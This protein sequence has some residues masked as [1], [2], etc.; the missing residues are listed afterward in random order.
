MLCYAREDPYLDGWINAQK[1]L[2]D[3]H[4][5]SI[6][7]EQKTIRL[8]D[9]KEHFGFRDG[10]SAPL[11]EGLRD[12]QTQLR[13]P[14]TQTQEK[15]I[16][17]GEFVLGYPNEYD[18]LTE[19]PVVKPGDDPGNWLPVYSEDPALKDL[20]KNGTYLVY[21]QLAQHVYR[22][23]K[24][25][26]ENSKEPAQDP[27]QAAVN[28]GA[29]IIGRW[30]GGSP[31]AVSPDHNDTAKEQENHFAYWKED[32]DGMKCPFG[33]HIRRTNPRDKLFGRT[34]QVSIEMIRKHQIIR[35]GRS[36]GLPLVESM[37]PKD[38]LAAQEDGGERGIAFICLAGNLSRQFEFLQNV[39]VRTPTLAGLFKD[40]D[41]LIA[42]RQ[43][44][45]EPLN[46]QF[47]CPAGPI[48]RKYKGMS[49]FTRL[50]GGAY[51]FLPG[52]KALHFIVNC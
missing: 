23:W 45:G 16:R 17:A 35:R 19:T 52:I 48:R 8:P 37:A 28:L 1:T 25:L 33:A 10:I 12:P 5:L 15:P 47:T 11:V 50:V 4:G 38:V 18:R 24:Y 14:H 2:F 40:A 3:T 39:W 36:Y 27:L 44:D 20:G 41:P 34:Q 13:D 46:D 7:K 49:Q 51:F 30:P 43:G 42:A 6:I 32:P 31:L 26:A 29:K 22:F 21:R 9:S